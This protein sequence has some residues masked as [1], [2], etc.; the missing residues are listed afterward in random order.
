MVMKSGREDG[1]DGKEEGRNKKQK[2]QLQA[3]TADT[4]KRKAECGKGFYG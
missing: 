2:E 4:E 3:A 1:R